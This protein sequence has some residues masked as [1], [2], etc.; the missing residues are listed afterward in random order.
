MKKHVTVILAFLAI[1][2]LHCPIHA[3]IMYGV[4][5]LGGPSPGYASARSVN[6]N[7]QI[8]GYTDA[9]GTPRAV[10][11][12]AIHL[13]E[14]IYLGGTVGTSGSQANC[15]SN[16]GQVVGYAASSSEMY[17]ATLFDPTGQGNNVDLGSGVAWSINDS[18]QIVG[19][20]GSANAMLFDATGQGNNIYLGKGIGD[21]IG[22]LAYCINNSGQIVG[23]EKYY[24]EKRH[25]V[26]FDPSGQGNNIDLGVGVAR[27]INDMGQIVGYSDSHGIADNHALVFDATGDGNNVDLGLGEAWSIN[28]IGQIVGAKHIS[29]VGWRAMFFDSTGNGSNIDLNTI[30]RPSGWELNGAYDINNDGWIVGFGIN[31]S[32]A[33]RAFLLIPGLPEPCTLSLLALGGLALRRRRK[34]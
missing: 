19:D 25:A 20:A 33:S 4:I 21:N 12:E 26:M 15:I 31:P 23:Y 13:G 10:L 5:D 24:T 17:R 32:G 7:G 9:G 34:G 6:N 22:S 29:G 8:A 28:D 1:L 14:K 11:F 18:G 16:S 3:D 27:H 30:V 2:V